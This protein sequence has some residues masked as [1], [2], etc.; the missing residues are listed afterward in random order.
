VPGGVCVAEPAAR[1]TKPF[2]CGVRGR[3]PWNQ[4]SSADVAV[5]ADEE[6]DRLV[7][8][9]GAATWV[10]VA[11]TRRTSPSGC[12]SPTHSRR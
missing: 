9:V 5:G 2:A 8:A 11:R 6:G 10:N 1:A 12:R 3:I 7:C 4:P